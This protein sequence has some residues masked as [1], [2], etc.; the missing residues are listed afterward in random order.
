[1]ITKEYHQNEDFSP[2]KLLKISGVFFIGYG[3]KA[4]KKFVLL[5]LINEEITIT[6][7]PLWP[8]KWI[9]CV[10]TAEGMLSIKLNTEKI[11]GEILE[12]WKS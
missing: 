4:T 10:L 12:R 7:V 3:R 8:N 1:M 9:P 2:I 5:K 6:T 11:Q